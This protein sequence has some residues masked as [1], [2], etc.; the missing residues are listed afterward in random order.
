MKEAVLPVV[1]RDG[2]GKNFSRKMRRDGHVPASLYGPK[3][4]PKRLSVPVRELQKLMRKHHVQNVMLTLDVDGAG[5]GSEKALIRELQRDPV[6]GDILHV[7]FHQIPMDRAIHLTIPVHLNGVASGVK[8]DGGI[9]QQIIRDLEISCLPTQIPDGVELDVTE[10][11]IG[12][13]IHVSDIKL[14]NI[15]ILTDVHRTVVTIVPPTV[16]KTAE[17]EA[18]EGGVVDAVGP[19]G[20]E[21]EDSDEEDEEKEE[22]K[23]KKEKH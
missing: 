20:A 21:P 18:A 3:I 22:K 9:M 16:A 4:Q 8:N 10:L 13:S 11:G 6:R 15:T 2:G 7:D 1:S 5:P 17:E 23:D 19:A 12:D 14:E